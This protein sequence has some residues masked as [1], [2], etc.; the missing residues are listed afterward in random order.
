MLSYEN[1]NAPQLDE[2]DHEILSALQKNARKAFTDIAKNLGVSSGTI[3]QRYNKLVELGIVTGS[4]LTIDESRLGFDVT[5]ILGVHLK[6]GNSHERVV[7][8]LRQ[9]RN[10]VEINYT[11]GTYALMVKIKTKSIKDFHELLTTKIQAI[12]EISSTESF[13]SLKEYVSRQLTFG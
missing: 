13:V 3:H 1:G 2:L 12:A 11:T 4:T 9:I 7:E 6:S 8:K 10:V 5:T